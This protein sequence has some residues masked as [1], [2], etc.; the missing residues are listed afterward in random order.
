MS[1]PLPNEANGRTV[2][3]KFAKGYKGGPGNP[4]AKRTAE[5]RKAM[6]EAVTPE[7]VRGA[8][9][10]LVLAARDG[11][12]VAIKELLDRTVG[13]VTQP[14]AGDADGTMPI[15]IVVVEGDK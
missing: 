6:M 11:D 4:Y 10:A 1:E 9:R 14:V 7:D 8:I 15:K 5:Y 3:G 2:G 12:V 13:K